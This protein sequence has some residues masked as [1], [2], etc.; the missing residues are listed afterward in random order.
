MLKIRLVFPWT[1]KKNGLPVLHLFKEYQLAGCFPFTKELKA[2][3][4]AQR[5]VQ[6]I[7]TAPQSDLC[8]IQGYR[9]SL[10]IKIKQLYAVIAESVPFEP[11][12]SK[13]CRENTTRKTKFKYLYQALI[14]CKNVEFTL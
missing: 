6:I 1:Y 5:L 2:V 11:N 14:R 9:A 12:I 13:N 4:I 10:V 8:T 7:N 3:R